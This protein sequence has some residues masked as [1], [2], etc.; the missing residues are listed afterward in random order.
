[1]MCRMEKNTFNSDC[2]HQ[3]IQSVNLS[4]NAV[5]NCMGNSDADA[6]HPLLQVDIMHMPDT[7]VSNDC[8]H[9]IALEAGHMTSTCKSSA[10]ISNLVCQQSCH[11]TVCNTSELHLDHKL[12][13]LQFDLYRQSTMHKEKTALV[14]CLEELC[15]YLQW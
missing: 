15:C 8:L 11:L 4:V 10:A 12:M 9:Q 2:A 1:M 5:Q 13:Q 6:E 3:Q 7:K 14:R